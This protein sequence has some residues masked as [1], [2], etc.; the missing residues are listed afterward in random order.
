MWKREVKDL[1]GYQEADKRV[2]EAALSGELKGR[3]A[4]G[5]SNVI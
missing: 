2:Q 5:A 4:C 3:T 1:Q